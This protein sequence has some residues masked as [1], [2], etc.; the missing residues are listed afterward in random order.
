MNN[1]SSFFEN[2]ECEYYP[3]HR[4]ID[5]I[6][7]LFCFCPL[8]WDCGYKDGGVGCSTCLF[9][10]RPES[11]PYIMQ[12]LKNMYDKKVLNKNPEASA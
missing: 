11:Y 9:P 5:N 7:C 1:N 4:D 10:H 12:Y 2:K 8:F 3:C 6:N